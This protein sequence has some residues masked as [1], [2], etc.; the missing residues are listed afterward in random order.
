MKT[1]NEG[2][3]ETIEVTEAIQSDRGEG[4]GFR[5]ITIVIG[6]AVAVGI[7]RVRRATGPKAKA[8]AKRRKNQKLKRRT[9]SLLNRGS[10]KF[11]T[12]GIHAAGRLRMDP[13]STGRSTH[14]DVCKN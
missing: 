5:G 9:D 7:A 12:P 11:L 13:T 2:K 4:R 8:K 1:T 14:P 3:K 6:V 10:E